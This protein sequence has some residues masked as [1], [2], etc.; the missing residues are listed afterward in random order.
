[1][2]ISMPLLNILSYMKGNSL[3]AWEA[4]EQCC[5][6]AIIKRYILNDLNLSIAL[7]KPNF[8]IN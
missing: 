4:L 2:G 5:I 7:C 1:M 8:I 3:K 6:V